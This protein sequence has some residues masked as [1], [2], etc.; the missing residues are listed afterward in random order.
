MIGL[1]I[2]CDA[3]SAPTARRLGHARSSMP[4]T[5]CPDVHQCT[6]VLFVFTTS[7]FSQHAP[8]RAR[9]RARAA[10]RNEQSLL[11]GA[12]HHELS[13]RHAAERAVPSRPT[14]VS[15]TCSR[16]MP[17]CEKSDNVTVTDQS[18]FP[19]QSLESRASRPPK[20][21][22]QIDLMLYRIIWLTYS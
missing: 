16:D 22:S 3:R 20:L 9:P 12:S 8:R 13:H 6:G 10:H 4:L 18:N 7:S 21:C 15:C 11:D 19:C 17:R 1:R 5:P 2:G 14:G